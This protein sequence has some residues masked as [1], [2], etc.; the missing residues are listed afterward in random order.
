MQAEREEWSGCAGF[1][2][3]SDINLQFAP[4]WHAETY[5]H[6]KKRYG[7]NVQGVCDVNRR[8][9][10]FFAG[11]PGSVGDPVAFQTASLFESPQE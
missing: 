10:F 9:I 7:F 11:F 8:F 3:G 4:E 2:D 6:R 1:I 5:F